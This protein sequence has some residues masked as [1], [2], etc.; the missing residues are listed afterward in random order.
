MNQFILTGSAALLAASVAQASDVN[1]DILSGGQG[2]VD[3]VAGTQ[4]NYEIWAELSD[5]SNEGLALL[6]FDLEFDGGV[7]AQADAASGAVQLN[8][9][10]PLGLSNPSGFGG[11][12]S[13]GNLL[14]VGG[15]QN[16][17]K[18]TF[19]PMPN[20]T[21]ITGI[22]Q[23]GSAVLFASGSLTVPATAGTYHLTLNDLIANVIRQ[24]ELGAGEFWAVD[25]AGAGTLNA[26]TVDVTDCAPVIYCTAKVNSQGC[27]S[28]IGSTG[29]AT[30]T[31]ADDLHIT[32]TNAINQKTGLLFWGT[33]SKDVPF[34]GGRLC[35]ESPFTRTT[36][37]NSGGSSGADDCTGVYDYHFTQAYMSSSGLSV[38][39]QVNAQYWYRDPSHVDGFGVGL[40]EGIQFVICP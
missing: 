7:L 9:A 33:D 25:S 32:A 28:A 22:G 15:A 20:G 24:G 5:A 36:I 8:F 26:L 38:G 37:Q 4:L 29:T 27:L 13:M 31:G 6:C 34:M 1:I 39:S 18:N 35:V 40:T 11:T 17:I 19:A 14:Q 10:A 30:L 3:A 2:T 23:P 12:S 21:V 16:T